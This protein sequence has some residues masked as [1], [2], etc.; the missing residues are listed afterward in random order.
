MNP[1][2][3]RTLIAQNKLLTSPLRARNQRDAAEIRAA[4]RGPRLR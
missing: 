3:I 4:L 1:L 2:L